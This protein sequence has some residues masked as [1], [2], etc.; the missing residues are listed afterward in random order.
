MR[1]ILVHF[2]Q[3]GLIFFCKFN[4][5]YRQKPLNFDEL[6]CIYNTLESNPQFQNLENKNC[7]LSCC[8]YLL[9]RYD[10][11]F[12][13]IFSQ[14]IIL[15]LDLRNNPI[16]DTYL[17]LIY[18]CI[19]FDENFMHS[20]KKKLEYLLK[21]LEKFSFHKKT[22][23]N[24]LLY[25]YYRGILQFRLGN[26]DETLKESMG[27]IL[28]IE[29]EKTQNTKYINFIEFKNK[30]FQIKL[31]EAKNETYELKENYN[32]LRDVYEKAKNDNPFLALKLGF[33]IY[34]NLY[35]QNL[36]KECVQILQ[37]M[38]LIIKN[39]EKQGV[40]PKKL[41]RFGLSIYCRTGLIGLL[42]SN[43][44]LIDFA[45]N[46]MSKGLLL[47][48]NDRNNKKIMS[49]LK[50]YTFALTLLKL[51]CNIY[52]EMPKNICNIF[53]KEFISD[54]FNKEG[55]YL[56]D[57]YCIDNKNINQCIINLNALNDNFDSSINDKAQK[58]VDYYISTNA[59]PGKNLLSNDAIFV[60]VVGLFDRIRFVSEKYLRDKNQ[61][62][63]EKYKTQIL[64]NS[65][66]FWRYINN[67]AET[68]PLLRTDFFKSIIIKIFSCC[69][70]IYYYNKD[71]N[72]LA[73]SIHH[74]D[75]LSKILNINENTPSYDLVYKVKGDYYFKKN[76]Y[77]T[78]IDY[79][80]NSIK[81]MN[82]KNPTK[83]AVF[84]N[85]GILYYYL[86]EKQA[87]VFNFG[88]AA[89]Y[90]KKVDEE[91]STFDIHKRNN[92]LT[93]KYNFTQTI[94]KEIK[95]Q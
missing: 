72:N 1:Q 52:V 79:Y 69:V 89:E 82:D 5:Y 87:S 24:Y 93:A 88:K 45:I 38:N 90:F 23:E 76:D 55:K 65:K 57:N 26:I 68:E 41:L 92:I 28:K 39:Y 84:F 62:N 86:G 22:K 35:K 3:E 32:L 64:L 30:L 27:I 63:Q 49:F 13:K 58:I 4:E 81:R 17:Y 19:D 20:D 71:F 42:L 18:N 78:S 16:N 75:N 91:K 2:G 8:L 15:L 67:N 56:G 80:N 59:T 48:K 11:K 95:N 83:P 74:F 50:A 14:K 85:L 66:T 77:K 44:Q 94:I 25:K 51:N 9:S 60:F 31:M 7:Y 40:H 43:K 46:E 29:E 6:M 53:I 12:L 70:H 21:Y 47:I 37:Q 10:E 36:Y 34:S 33:S 54:K 61:Y 73:S